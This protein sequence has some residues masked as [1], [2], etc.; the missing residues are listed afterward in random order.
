[1]QKKTEAKTQHTTIQE[2][3][4]KRNQR[5]K[6]NRELSR[7]TGRTGMYVSETPKEKRTWRRRMWSKDDTQARTEVKFPWEL[8]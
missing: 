4:G 5:R 6:P 3:V 7:E 8:K 1:M 2:V